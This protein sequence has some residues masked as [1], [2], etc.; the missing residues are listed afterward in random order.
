MNVLLPGKGL[1]TE[2]LEV[3]GV[4]YFS[5]DN[6]NKYSIFKIYNLIKS[7][8]FDIVYGNTTH[9]SSRNALIASKLSRVPFICHVR[10][11]GWGKSWYKL[12][13]LNFADDII[14]VSNASLKS[15]SRFIKNDDA[16][17]VHNG[18]S[19]SLD[20][21]NLKENQHLITKI[22]INKNDYN[23]L[24]VGH[25]C[26]RKGQ[27]LA[28]NSMS[29]VVKKNPRAKLYLIGSTNRDSIYVKEL[30]KRIR[31][32]KLDKH[33]KICGFIS[34]LSKFYKLFD[35]YI[36]TAS[37]DPHPRSVIEAMNNSLPVVGLDSGGVSETIVDNQTGVLVPKNSL[38]LISEAIID[39][40]F[41]ERKSKKFGINSKIHVTKN[42]RDRHT[43][44]K[45]SIIIN[46]RVSKFKTI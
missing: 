43:S 28:V 19:D 11:M 30:K 16:Y 18:V 40:S 31:E 27:I 26:E 36:H 39:L 22:G 29:E 42:F 12:G 41:N 1:F 32:L 21:I 34:D 23:I 4:K 14:A 6:L 33:I 20:E 17:V 44:K 13:F 8:K 46:E 7:E 2:K 45:I 10:E 37:V 25:I 5:F 38:D 3:M 24:S 35:L 15:V 9:G